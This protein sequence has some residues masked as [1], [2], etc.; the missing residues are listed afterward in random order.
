MAPVLRGSMLDA[1]ESRSP[2][3]MSTTR[4]RSASLMTLSQENLDY[5]GQ[6]VLGVQRSD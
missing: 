3:R 1:R 2:N 5:V 6:H 4:R